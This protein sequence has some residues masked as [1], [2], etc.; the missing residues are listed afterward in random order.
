MLAPELLQYVDS[1]KPKAN[2]I[3]DVQLA[4]A[5]TAGGWSEEV[6]KE[7]LVYFRASP[8]SATL[9]PILP[10]PEPIVAMPEPHDVG[11][12]S[13]ASPAPPFEPIPIIATPITPLPPQPA[14]FS[15]PASPKS[16]ALPNVTFMQKERVMIP[17]SVV[18]EMTQQ[19]N[20]S[21]PEASMDTKPSLVQW[22]TL[23]LIAIAFSGGLFLG[24][25][26]AIASAVELVKGLFAQNLLTDTA[27]LV[28]LVPA[29]LISVLGIV[30]S[31]MLARKA[32]RKSG[33]AVATFL[34]GSAVHFLILLAAS[35]LLTLGLAYGGPSISE[36]ISPG[37]SL[38]LS[39]AAPAYMFIF[40]IGF[41]LGTALLLVSYL[42]PVP[43]QPSFLRG[44]PSHITIIL[45]AFLAAGY[46]FNLFYIPAV[47][48]NKKEAC[49]LVYDSGMRSDCFVQIAAQAASGN[50]I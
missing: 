38:V 15:T 2:E 42:R 4:E 37:V 30:V 39:H 50:A 19:A 17:K 28:A 25:Q 12:V 22:I 49:F 23:T 36:N 9:P 16:A 27:A 18:A 33:K 40:F 32:Y 11:I 46:V 10:P 8:L 41:V 20:S 35:V 7:A 6:V 5:V 34:Y 43:L 47:L 1:L 3:T 21:L 24:I 44:A 14:A 31:V 26:D 48:A 29:L 13:G 45:V